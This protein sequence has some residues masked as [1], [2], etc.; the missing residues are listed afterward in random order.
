M[1]KISRSA[2]ISADSSF[3]S[4]GTSSPL[5]GNHREISFEATTPPPQYPRRLSLYKKSPDY[6]MS[7]DDFEELALARLEGK[8]I[9][10]CC[11][12]LFFNV[13]N[14]IFCSIEGSGNGGYSQFTR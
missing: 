11:L 5:R 1:K 10:C 2:P 12:F 3:I 9:H 14:P 8:L 7:I 4:T 13:T 6:E